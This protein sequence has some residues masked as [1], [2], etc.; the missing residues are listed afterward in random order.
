MTSVLSD[1]STYSALYLATLLVHLALMSFPLGG[2]VL[3]C[4]FE[5]F[6]GEEISNL[7]K[8][9]SRNLAIC[10]GLAMTA[11]IAPLLFLSLVHPQAYYNTGAILGGWRP[12]LLVPLVVGVYFAYVQRTSDF[13][14]WPGLARLA[15]RV[16]GLL[17]LSVVALIFIISRRIG[18][19]PERWHDWYLELPLEDLVWA[20]L[21]LL[22]LILTA[23][24]VGCSIGCLWLIG[25]EE[26]RGR[27]SAGERFQAEETLLRLAIFV[28]LGLAFVCEVLRERQGRA[29]D[30]DWWALRS[31]L[32]LMICGFVIRL[33]RVGPG[34][35]LAT[36]GGVASLSI[37]LLMREEQRWKLL[38]L[39][40]GRHTQ[41]MEVAATKGGVYLFV[42]SAVV[43]AV[44]IL[45]VLRTIRRAPAVELLEEGENPIEEI[46]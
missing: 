26:A 32:F 22:G 13:R 42:A 43:A 27:L 15:V 40:E 46:T 1:L 41:T 2:S 12:L 9:I 44:G 5:I 34:R 3:L 8:L 18:E 33:N 23:A 28:S 45:L 39:G 4:L 29:I 38:A 17:S 31:A 35:L 11:G 6:R 7:K 37:V 16:G 30:F 25:R 14:R 19:R 20:A 10:I 24:T 36:I 21:P